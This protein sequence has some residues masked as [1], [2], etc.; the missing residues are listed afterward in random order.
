ML[1]SSD[2]G[3]IRI[4]YSKNPFGKKRDANGNW[5]NTYESL[6]TYTPTYSP[7]GTAAAGPAS[8]AQQYGADGVAQAYAAAEQQQP[9]PMSAV[10]EQPQQEQPQEQPQQP[11]QQSF[12]EPYAAAVPGSGKAGVDSPAAAAF[13]TPM[14][15][16]PAGTAPQ[17][18]AATNG[19][20]GAKPFHH[21]WVANSGK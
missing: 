16:A 5:I 7:G 11:Q 14:V 8:G 17:F 21:C 4:Q 18:A 13:A 1:N 3:G 15:P 20:Q 9:Q 12:S 2:R 6:S 19:I 10:A